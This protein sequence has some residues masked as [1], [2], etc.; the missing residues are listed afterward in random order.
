LLARGGQRQL[1]LMARGLPGLKVE[2][3]RV[4]PGAINHLVSQTGGDLDDP[5]F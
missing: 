3:G 5:Y 2:I 1:S 4:Q